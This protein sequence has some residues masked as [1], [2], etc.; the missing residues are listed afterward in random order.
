MRPL[1]PKA[2][3]AQFSLHIGA[4][5]SCAKIGCDYDKKSTPRR[6]DKEHIAEVTFVTYVKYMLMNIF[7]FR[8]LQVTRTEFY[9]RT[10]PNAVVL[11]ILYDD[12]VLVSSVLHPIVRYVRDLFVKNLLNADGCEAPQC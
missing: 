1:Y 7:A 11:T 3:P 12:Q 9:V 8:I 6:H 10:V 2:C 5:C 4:Q